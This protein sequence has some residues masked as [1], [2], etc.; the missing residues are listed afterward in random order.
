[1]VFFVE[2]QLIID[3]FACVFI[4]VFSY[5]FLLRLA[6]N[7][8]ELDMQLW[9]IYMFVQLKFYKSC[10]G[11]KTVYQTIKKQFCNNCYIQ[12]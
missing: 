10:D 4:S 7:I 1:M 3:L 9:L 6:I 2:L 5:S 12:R 8:C 11:V